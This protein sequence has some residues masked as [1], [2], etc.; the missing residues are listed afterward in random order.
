M[1]AA[2]KLAQESN[3]VSEATVHMHTADSEYIHGSIE[4]MQSALLARS[5]R[6]SSRE[7]TNA[8]VED[9]DESL[10]AVVS[11]KFFGGI[12][13]AFTSVGNVLRDAGMAVGTAVG[14]A[15]L[16]VG[17][18]VIEAPKLTMDGLNSLGRGD[19]KG[20]AESIGRTPLAVAKVTIHTARDLGEI[21]VTQAVRLAKTTLEHARKTAEQGAKLATK[22]GNFIADQAVAFGNEV[23]K[24]GPLAAGLGTAVWN[25]MKKYLNC[26]KES[27]S[28]C[29]MLIGRQCDCNAG[30]YV[31][32]YHDRMEMRCVFSRTS[33]FSKGFGIKAT[34]DSSGGGSTL[35]GSEYSQAYKMYTDVMKSRK[36]LEA[37]Q[38]PQPA[39]MCE[40]ELK[41]SVDGVTQ[42]NPDITVS[43]RTNGDTVISL[44][45][46]VQGSYDTLVT[47]QGSCS[48]TLK[49]G[50]PKKPKTKVVCAGKFCVMISLQMVASLVG[51]GV[52]TGTIDVSNDVDFQI[53]A[54]ATVKKN[55]ESDV[56]V[57]SL[58]TKHKEAVKIGASA[59]ASLRFS[60]GPELVVWPMPGIPITFA[61]KFHAEAKAKGTIKH[62]SS[63]LLLDQ[64]SVE[65]SLPWE[66]SNASLGLLEAEEGRTAKLK[67]C[68]AAAVSLYT[69]FTITGFAIPKWLKDLLKDGFLK[70]RIKEAINEGARAMIK[71]MTGPLQ[72]IPGASAVT[73][74]IMDAAREAGNLLAGLIPNLGLK[75]D[76]KS[77]YILKPQKLFCKEVWTTPDF[78]NSPC[79]DQL[80]CGTAGQGAAD[81]SEVEVVPPEQVRP[82]TVNRQPGAPGCPNGLKM[83]DRFIE[84]GKFRIA[85]HYDQYLSVSHKDTRKVAVVWEKNG[86]AWRRHGSDWHRY[87]AWGRSNGLGTKIKFGFEFIQIG[88]FRLG[89]VDDRHLSIS[90]TQDRRTAMI[91]RDDGHQTWGSRGDWN[92]LDRPEGAPVGISFGDGW[93]QIGKF[94]IG[95][96][97]GN[98]L[99]I[100]HTRNKNRAIEVYTRD[101]NYKTGDALNGNWGNM[102]GRHPAHWT[103]PSIGD[104]AHGTCRED[105]GGWGDRFV[106][107]GDWRLAAIDEG[108]FAF[109]HKN[110]KNV[111]IFKSDGRRVSGRNSDRVWRRPL[112]FPHGITFGANFIQIG[113][114]RLA[115]LDN[116]H[117]S[118]SHQTNVDQH[119]HR[120]AGQTMQIWRSNSVHD[121]STHPGPRTDWNAWHGHHARTAGPAGVGYGDRYLQIGNFRI[122]VP[123]DADHWLYMTRTDDGDGRVIQGWH[124]DGTVNSPGQRR[125]QF[126]PT[127]VLN[128]RNIQ[129][130]CGN[131]QA[132]LGS[133]SGITAGPGFI[134]LGDWRLAAVSYDYFSISH[135]SR[136][137]A[138]RFDRHGRYSASPGQEH[139]G[140]DDRESGFVPAGDL[141]EVKIGDRFIEFGKFWRLGEQSEDKLSISHS[142]GN[143][144]MVYQKNGTLLGGPRT[145]NNLFNRLTTTEP[146]G[147]TFGDRF[148]QIGHFRIGD[149]DGWHFSISHVTSGM[150]QE[151]YTGDGHR[152]MSN[153]NRRDWQT[154]GRPLQ[155]C[156]IFPEKPHLFSFDT[157]YAFYNPVHKRYLQLNN[158]AEM[159][160]VHVDSGPS[161]LPYWRA[162]ERFSVVDA[163]NGLVSLHNAKNNRFMKM[164]QSQMMASPI[165]AAN[166][167]PASGWLSEYFQIVDAG[168]G[169]V[170]LHNPHYN[171]FVQMINHGHVQATGHRNARDLKHNK[172]WSWEK[173]YMVPVKNYLQPGTWVGLFNPTARRFLQIHGSGIGCSGHFP[174]FAV[175]QDGHTYER[176]RV[177]DAGNGMVALH[178]HIFNRYVSMIWNGHAHVMTRSSESPD[179]SV[180]LPNGWADSTA[181]VPVPINPN[182]NEIALWHPGHSRAVWMGGSGNVGVSRHVN[183]QDM[184]SGWVGETFRVIPI[185]DPRIS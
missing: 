113:S 159:A 103:C 108:N 82:P 180:E 92:T 24:V 146:K 29:Q 156:K 12:V 100:M 55:G 147:V 10:D 45:G 171:R 164:S 81:E 79:A 121:K 117:F 17:N 1:A 30:S 114:F 101:G 3:T 89:A 48:Y 160:S 116:D 84:L 15:A 173:F 14:N 175:L 44:S 40:T 36:G 46:S 85:E 60:V 125:R 109:A 98:D 26:L 99:A 140:W 158:V 86:N 19:L 70:D 23:A 145:D 120:H 72:C 83:G 182:T 177:V 150:T 51:K 142:S 58:G 123:D 174:L 144:A 181:F 143:T 7:R 155:D 16:V 97:G 57:N 179:T 61:P 11:A 129:W 184:N 69:D 35:P 141:Q 154:T 94:R 28:L 112:G 32:V 93:I 49:R 170:G 138:M 157:L 168:D 9:L 41:V 136:N 27:T 88:K 13:D 127:A 4:D 106:Q 42:W 124:K 105:F 37:M 20:F 91:L 80:G 62:P 5:S 148:V 107:L 162:F 21:A 163:G 65:E 167:L 172:G 67:Q 153:G 166:R 185:P 6:S 73:N 128:R 130:H 56:T 176:F 8:S 133:C 165:K 52:L 39:G 96:S 137:T 22:V 66:S 111:E 118:I 64:E 75:W 74:Q 102:Y 18:R 43:V 77:I 78:E 87:D 126:S 135:R 119:G 54:T 122:G 183:A 76:F 149:V 152:H 71:M 31:K 68:H 95:D 38:S 139:N 104:I 2:M 47:G 131:I 25:E 50:L 33:E 151:I 161:D 34:R 132:K 90:H 53:S 110:G 169:M 178:N 115:A 134:Q 59:E 63:S